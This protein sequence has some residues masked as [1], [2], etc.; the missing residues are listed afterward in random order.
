MSAPL[1]VSTV[2]SPP[3]AGRDAEA[4]G[5]ERE[6]VIRVRAGDVDAYGLLLLKHGHSRR[7]RAWLAAR[8]LS[9]DAVEELAQD[10]FVTA[11]Q[12]IRKFRPGTDFGAWLRQIAFQLMRQA[13]KKYAVQQKPAA[14]FLAELAREQ[15]T[16][17]AD[18]PLT[19]FLDQCLL[20]APGSM[21]GL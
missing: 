16:E 7:L 3:V 18:D 13:R 4:V 10:A 5:A 15:S 8:A 6:L 9:P 2:P 12:R 19:E 1:T 17:A 21:R 14:N 20:R 11:F